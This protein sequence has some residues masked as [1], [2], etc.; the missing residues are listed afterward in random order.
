MREGKKKQKQ[1]NQQTKLKWL[2][3]ERTARSVESLWGSL[4]LLK[5]EVV[6]EFFLKFRA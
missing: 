2:N 4:I 6:K 1:I 5:D 3:F